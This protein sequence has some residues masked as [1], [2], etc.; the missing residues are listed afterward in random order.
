MILRLYS[1]SLFIIRLDKKPVNRGGKTVLS[2][3]GFKRHFRV[4]RLRMKIPKCT[5]AHPGEGKKGFALSDTGDT[6]L[7]LVVPM[8][9]GVYAI[10]LY[11][12]AKGSP[13]AKRRY[14][15]AAAFRALSKRE[16]VC[17]QKGEK[18]RRL[19]RLLG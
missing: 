6:F 8:G 4:G 16:N 7:R 14:C 12:W 15:L 5:S 9:K 17:R 2:G 18:A 1:I 13:T 3:G 19:S 10:F 11:G